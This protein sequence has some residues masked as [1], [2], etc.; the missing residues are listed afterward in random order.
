MPTNE[1]TRRPPLQYT[2]AGMQLLIGTI[3]SNGRIDVSCRPAGEKKVFTMEYIALTQDPAR[4]KQKKDKA[5]SDAC[6]AASEDSTVELV[7]GEYPPENVIR[8]TLSKVFGRYFL[9]KLL[10]RYPSEP[11]G[12]I[13]FLAVG[14]YALQKLREM[15][16]VRATDQETLRKMILLWGDRPMNEILPS[17][18]GKDLA[19][20]SDGAAKECVR[21]L[22]RIYPLT[23]HREA[24]N[25]N[26]WKNY[27]LSGRRRKYSHKIRVRTAL[28][29]VALSIGQIAAVISRCVEKI[30]NNDAHAEKYLAALIML[31]EGLV[32]EEICAL[33]ADSMS[34]IGEAMRRLAVH[35][36]VV[37][38][39]GT[40]QNNERIRG[41]RH[42]IDALEKPHKRSLG[43]SDV[44]AACWD[45]YYSLHPGFRGTDQLLLTN[46]DNPNR[47]LAPSRYR[48]WLD[49]TFGD[50]LPHR[51]LRLDGEQI[52]STYHTEDYFCATA[53]YL[54]VDR[55][56][57]AAEELRYHDGRAPKQ[58]DGKHYAGFDAPAELKK[59]GCMQTQAIAS[60]CGSIDNI[61]CKNSAKNY[62]V[63]GKA[64]HILRV[65]AEIYPDKILQN[66]KNQQDVMLRLQ[67]LGYNG[68]IHIEKK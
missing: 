49:D 41:K 39:A 58:M 4:K 17:T 56:G 7:V 31:T 62:T 67:S 8:W 20:M 35:Y 1:N 46:P 9:C 52:R 19:G 42:T 60:V 32:A 33:R 50:L 11:I 36:I 63:A 2:Y 66:S 15:S 26:I 30:Y 25:L 40:K 51:V 47:I 28:L 53:K 18:C 21:L 24:E 44:L 27:T 10:E 55:G 23:M 3:K 34:Q 6:V 57:Y 65:R 43:V 61:N 29:N 13:H 48:Q 14:E 54:L 38:Q 22:R 59:M 45:I 5:A 37:E 16:D 64:G 68:N 12:Y